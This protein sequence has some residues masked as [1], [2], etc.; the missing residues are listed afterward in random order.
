MKSRALDGKAGREIPT[1]VRER[2][3]WTGQTGWR[4][5]ARRLDEKPAGAWRSKQWPSYTPSYTVLRRPT[6][7]PTSSYNLC[8]TREPAC[9]AALQGAPYT[10]YAS[11]AGNQVVSK[12]WAQTGILRRGSVA[13][14]E[15][16]GS[17][18][19]STAGHLCAIVNRDCAGLD[20]KPALAATRTSRAAQGSIPGIVGSLAAGIL[21]SKS[22]P[23]SYRRAVGER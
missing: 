3:P 15:L 10:S 9:R 5:C 7:R 16:G 8:R 6:R 1:R 4:P 20:G 17:T 14:D 19:A 2:A 12:N 11:Y 18:I 21:S 23:E 13:L 22:L